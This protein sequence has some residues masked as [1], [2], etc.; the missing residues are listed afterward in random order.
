MTTRPS[1]TTRP[2][3]TRLQTAHARGST[4][5]VVTLRRRQIIL[6]RRIVESQR[7]LSTPAHVH[8]QPNYYRPRRRRARR[9]ILSSLLKVFHKPIRHKLTLSH[10]LICKQKAY[11][12]LIFCCYASNPVQCKHTVRLL[13]QQT[14][15]ASRRWIV[16]TVLKITSFLCF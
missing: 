15:D 10:C 12:I 9:Q 1:T 4:S 16:C 14:N 2:E 7:C 11:L 8:L 5:N 13:I 3:I 6:Q